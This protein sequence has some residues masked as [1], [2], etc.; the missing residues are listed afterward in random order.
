VGKIRDRS[1][2]VPL[3]LLEIERCNEATKEKFS[4][5]RFTNPYDVK[6]GLCFKVQANYSCSAIKHQYPG[7][8]KIYMNQSVVGL[9]FSQAAIGAWGCD[10]CATA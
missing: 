6:Y 10:K 7:T 5:P 9:H 3:R 1:L 4:H 8:P 2:D